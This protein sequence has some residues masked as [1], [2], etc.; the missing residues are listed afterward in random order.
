M[1]IPSELKE[2]LLSELTF[3]ISKIQSETDPKRKS[4][5]LSAAPGAVDRAMRFHNDGGL[6]LLFYSLSAFYGSINGLL[7]R[8]ASGD[9]AVLPPNDL[10]DKVIE[11]M[12]ELTDRI[13]DGERIL[14]NLERIS[15]LTYVLTGAGYYTLSYLKEVNKEP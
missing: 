13:S 6:H 4:Y 15:T 10:W 11:H 2:R 7:T 5:F 14:P 12:K 9:T 1:N 3:V 8:I